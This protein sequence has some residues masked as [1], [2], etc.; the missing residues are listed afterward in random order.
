MKKIMNTSLIYFVLA[1]AGD[2]FYREFTKWNGY[3]EPTTLGVLH[4]HLLVMGTVLF[5]LIALF[6]KITDLEKNSL[7]KKFFVLYNV[8]LP[9]MVVMM[10]IRGIVQVLAIDLGKMGNGMLSG[11][12]G[13]SHITMMVSLLMLLIALKKEMVKG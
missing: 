10:L 7:F 3:T 4:V 8:A 13:L 5:L 9:F 2:V 6:T 12:A 11:F 1:M